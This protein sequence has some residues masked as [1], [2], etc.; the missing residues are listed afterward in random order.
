MFYKCTDTEIDYFRKYPA[1]Y[2]YL[3]YTELLKEN[4]I[5]YLIKPC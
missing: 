2:K 1:I 3:D 4:Q 5:E